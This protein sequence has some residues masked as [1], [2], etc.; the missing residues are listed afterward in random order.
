M[1]KAL[2]PPGK[3]MDVFGL[4]SQMLADYAAYTRSFIRIA[5]ERIRNKVD[6]EIRGGL[7]WPDPLLQLNPSFEPGTSIESLVS[8]GIL[9][10][11]CANIFRIKSSTSDV[12]RP[13]RLHK[14]Q[15]QAIRVAAKNEPYVVTTGTGS[16]KS[17]TYIIP[18]VD[19]ILKTGTGQGIKAIIV[20]PMNALANSQ[21]EE[22]HKFLNR[23]TDGAKSLVTFGRYTGQETEQERESLLSQPPDILL[24]N[25]VM[26][27]LI[28]TR[29]RE[30]KLV[31]HAGNLR[32]L[33]FDELHTYRGRQGA[34][35]AMLV[36]RCREAFHSK[37]MRCVGTSA[38]M[39][40]AGSSA[41]QSQVVAEVASKIFGEHVPA[42]N[43]IGETLRR[44]TGEFDFND[45][46]VKAELAKFVKDLPETTTNFDEFC[47]LPMA[48]WIEDTFGLRRE[49]S[50]GR[51]IRQIPSK[52][53]SPDGAAQ[54]LANL[55]GENPDQC[56]LAIQRTLYAGS[57]CKHP[58]TQFPVFAFR[59]HQFISRGD[60]VW[61]TLEYE[62]Q[63]TLT[64]KPQQYVP[65]DRNKI[66]LPIVFCRHC[67]QEYY[68]VDRPAHG[69]DGSIVPRESFAKSD[70]DEVESGYLYISSQSPWSG[71]L[72][73]VLRRIPEDWIDYH[74]DQ[75][76]IKRKQDIPKVVWLGTNG[77]ESMEGVQAA[78]IKAPFRFC[79]NPACGISHN[80]RQRSDAMKL[81]TIGVDGRS[82]ASTVLAL[83]TILQLRVD[84][85]LDP[86]ARKLL[87]FTDNRQDASLQ[88]GHF[89]DFVEV[90]LIRSALY[91]AM[92][93]RG[94]EGLRYDDL[95]Y[96][97]EKALN[98]P[99]N[100]YSNSPDLRGVPAIEE[101]RKAL[102]SVLGYFVYRDLERGWRV[103]SP[104][105]E[106]CGLLE[107]DYLGL[108][109]LAADQELF[110]ELKT[111]AAL[112]A[113]TSEQRA[114]V[115]KVLLDHLRRSLAVKEDSLD[116]NYQDRICQQS[117][118]RLCEP[119]VLEEVRE[120][121]C[122][123]TAWPRSS[124]ESDHWDDINISPRSN[125]GQWI[126]KNGI[127]AD[128]GRPITLD[129]TGD[130]I[131]D[132]FR[133]MRAHGL[134]V[135]TRSAPKGTLIPG[136]QIPASVLIWRPG[137][138]ER[139]M[140]DPLRMTK[141]KEIQLEANQYFVAFYKQFAEIGIG[142]EAREH[143]AQVQSDERINREQAFREGQLPILFCSPTMELGV[144]ISQLNVVNMRNVPP[145][146]AN[147]A[148]RSGRAGR[149][150]QPAL[151]YTYCSGFS[152]HDQ[153][154]FKQP[155][156]MVAGVVTAPRLDLL[157]RDLIESHVHAIWL[158]E[159]KL[160]LGTT[161]SEILSVSEDD[162]KLPLTN[163][164][165]EKLAEA[166]PKV[167]TLQRAKRLLESIGPELLET[168]WYREDWLEDVIARLPQKFDDAC[169]R[170][171]SLYR[172]AVQQRHLQNRIIG[173]H[174][175]LP[176][177]RDRAKRLRA[178]AEAQIALLTNPKNSFEGD[179]YSYRYFAS[180]GFLPG[181]NFPRLP[182]SCFVPGR[183][184]SRGRDEYLSR[185]RF[186]AIAEFGPRAVVYHEGTRYRVNKVNLAFDE[187]T[188]EMT[189]SLMKLC[190][191][192]G[193]GH[194][195][196]ER[197]IDNCEN[198]GNVL[199]PQD[200]VRAMVRLQNVT[201]KMA[202]RITSD[203]EERLRIGYD[204]RTTFR[205]AISNGELD[206][207]KAEASV[208]EQKIAT[209]CYGDVA[210]IWRINVGW[211]QRRPDNEFGFLLDVERGYWAAN[212]MSEDDQ[213][214]PLSARVKRVVPF[215]QDTRNAL[216]FELEGAQDI[217]FMA[218]LQA[219]LKNGIQ[220]VFQLEAS[221]LAV[222]PLPNTG[223]RR[224]LFFY[225][226]SEGG[227]GV[228][229][230]IAENRDILATV[231]R[232]AIEIC[233]FDPD[234]G[235]D[236]AK[237]TCAAACYDCLLEY[238]NQP[239]HRHI[240]RHLILPLLQ[241]LTQST[242]LVSGSRKSRT[243][244]FD[245]LIRQCDSGLERRWLEMVRDGQ[246]RLPSHAQHIISNCY[247]RPD[248]YYADLNT[249]IYIDG[250]VHDEDK[251]VKEDREIEERLAAAG[252]LTIRFH[253]QA[254]WN[255]IFDQYVEIFGERRRENQ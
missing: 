17:L 83:S 216:T 183:R 169:N 229:R 59:L 170:W 87:S 167:N 115:I 68:R 189:E 100:L 53:R 79:L 224:I 211:K 234:T 11:D 81:S 203:E 94:S 156:Q 23:G 4:H 193:Y 146:P 108:E 215:V 26:L 195:V 57:Q 10:E 213:E 230:Q 165:Q 132:L 252:H 184:N 118:Q 12:G 185:P 166:R 116:R 199:S 99:L 251:L 149:S 49:P 48:S 196:H 103:T 242:T 24:T 111:H 138:G 253:H 119:W 65:G 109:A 37:A 144:D 71:E 22:L 32:F 246:M 250:P 141:A 35:V 220:Q 29:I 233:H 244:H 142:L 178:Q 39:A 31:A 186:L 106:Q 58:E 173:D 130:I 104:N 1:S 168:N 33:V 92:A 93:A 67:G 207:R 188:Q 206:Y 82:T 7:L 122:S 96:A 88:A 75:P 107:F 139:P 52:L 171:R 50:S 194:V 44:A 114:E 200:E 21:R 36:R 201:A 222:E 42:E 198:C 160:D 126:R 176:T 143:T 145:T 41:E 70:N 152:P 248:F 51:L 155:Q 232:K 128:L 205:F 85:A 192:C 77:T 228:L 208:D 9:H 154:Y 72:E 202:D 231:A 190:P 105:L 135:E 5:D 181:Y 227:A 236:L 209:L 161:L 218:T 19:H 18:A 40:S 56:E 95:V 182:L 148:Q 174:S 98:L 238:G 175:R 113:A 150:G 147:Y 60:T 43:V 163:S 164:V 101:T 136:Y 177:D 137:S 210:T 204:L 179:F 187:D 28:L 30:G 219:A 121:V 140:I 235:N 91:R 237:E 197:P 158:S 25:Y 62:D 27:E 97:V 221:E 180:E 191:R 129:E 240:D 16:G 6:E 55:L 73:D 74:R 3:L 54:H 157:N 223:D 34:D 123:G 151:V 8:E 117:G 239:D 254:D 78:F 69:Q 13:L 159:A 214:D 47:R 247:T 127:L 255:A 225:E 63:R 172:A 110:D 14:H 153:Y 76:R 134:V 84:E 120:M 241:S 66:L 89:N 243:D 61:G 20:Y 90:G 124:A 2:K 38:T 80:P 131:I 102:R 125:F 46:K 15:E 226:A 112:T 133:C 45:E 86:T 64:L 217:Q 162:L 245:D 249:A 212:K